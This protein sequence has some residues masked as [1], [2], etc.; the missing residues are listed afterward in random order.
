MHSVNAIPGREGRRSERHPAAP[1]MVR[2]G[3]TWRGGKDKDAKGSRPPPPNRYAGENTVKVNS[4]SEVPGYCGRKLAW[5]AANAT[6]YYE[7]NWYAGEAHSSS[8]FTAV[9]NS[10]PPGY[11][12]V[13]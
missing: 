13:S 9:Q 8:S 11:Q 12:L 3:T 5:E 6:K 2:T 10:S 7:N 4:C 1:D